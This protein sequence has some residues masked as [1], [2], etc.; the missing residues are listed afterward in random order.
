MD[1]EKVMVKEMKD[2]KPLQK[3]FSFVSTMSNDKKNFTVLK[4][5]EKAYK[6]DNGMVSMSKNI[7]MPKEILQEKNVLKI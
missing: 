2:Y 4:E 1:K 3:Y 6:K 5:I 7:T